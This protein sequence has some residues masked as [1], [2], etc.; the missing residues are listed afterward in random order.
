MDGFADE[1]YMDR[2]YFTCYT[3]G[4]KNYQP[5]EISNILITYQ[6]A[7]GSRVVSLSAERGP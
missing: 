7:P 2:G 3:L 1:E 4:S 6:E 5:R